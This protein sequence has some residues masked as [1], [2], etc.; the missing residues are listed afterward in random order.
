MRNICRQFG[1]KP[2]MNIFE[3]WLNLQHHFKVNGVQLI[4]KIFDVA[5]SD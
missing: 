3:L 2:E 4:E 5:S 1:H